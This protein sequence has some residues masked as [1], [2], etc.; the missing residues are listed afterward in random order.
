M[1]LMTQYF[2]HECQVRLGLMSPANPISLTGTSYQLEKFLKH[3]APT[4]TYLLNSIFDD[5]TYTT[6]SNY[7]VTG[8]ISGYLEID[9]YGRK[10][11]MWFAG[12][13]TG[14]EYRNGIFHAPTNGV[15]IVLP[16]DDA[17]LHAFPIVASPN[18]VDYCKSCGKP[19]PMW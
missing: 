1:S 5:P 9:H 13:R 6:Y 7:I 3:T 4:V 11:L 10:N 16:E 14:A 17:K 18:S 19:H 2:C 15:K 8:S 12:E